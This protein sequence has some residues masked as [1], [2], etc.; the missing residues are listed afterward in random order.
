MVEICYENTEL[1]LN[2]G[3]TKVNAPK[4]VRDLCKLLNRE[5][6]N[7]ASDLYE[8]MFHKYHQDVDD[9]D[10]VNNFCIILF[11]VI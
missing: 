11:V 10:E 1:I 2:H 8:K 4:H 5:D 9:P 3:A 6:I 7:F